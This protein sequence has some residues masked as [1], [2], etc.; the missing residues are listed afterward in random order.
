MFL[1][2]ESTVFVWIWTNER[3]ALCLALAPHLAHHGCPVLPPGELTA[4]I[5]RPRV[6]VDIHHVT[7]GVVIPPGGPRHQSAGVG[8]HH[9]PGHLH[10]VELTPGLVED[11]PEDDAGVVAPLL[12]PSPVLPGKVIPGLPGDISRLSLARLLHLTAPTQL[13][14]KEPSHFLPF[15]G[16]LWHK[17]SWLS[18]TESIS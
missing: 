7:H 14:H 9:G 8:G 10:R 4:A 15:A 13:C 17:E 2:N 1:T 5:T 11:D 3:S 18:Y 12:Q 6:D 16:S